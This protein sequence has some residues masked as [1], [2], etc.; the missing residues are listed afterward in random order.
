MDEGLGAVREL[1]PVS[2]ETG[3]KLER[4]VEI[5]RKWQ[6]ADNLIAPGTVGGI[7]RRHVQDSAQAVQLF[8][9]A[10]RWLDLGSGAGFP[11][12]VIAIL[13]SETPGTHV[14]LVESNKR[15]CAFLRTVIRETSIPATM[16]E[17]RVEAVL[18]DWQQPIDRVSARALAPL[19]LLL[20][21]AE[22]VMSVERGQGAPAAF[23]KGRDYKRE[24]AEA[25]QT[26][27]FDLVEHESRVGEG[28]VILEIARLRR[29]PHSRPTAEPNP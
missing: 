2:R 25:S 29:Q 16:H 12:L 1:V 19:A 21:L 3:V 15:K 4:F 5:L 10:R 7:W 9:E 17:G 22:P 14:H 20:A 13:G 6:V 23:H 28:G 24:L 18:R 8:P 26:F 27:A 11:G